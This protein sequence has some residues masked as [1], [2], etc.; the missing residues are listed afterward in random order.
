MDSG[1]VTADWHKV[2]F[3][4]ETSASIVLWDNHFVTRRVREE[5][6]PKCIVKTTKHPATIM[7]W[8]CMSA[9][10]V[11]QVH[12]VKKTVDCCLPKYSAKQNSPSARDMYGE[13]FWFFQDGDASCHWGQV[14]NR[15]TDKERTAQ[16]G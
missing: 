9:K 16:K 2:V 7:I 14:T 3:N 13:G 11:G 6:F 4:D 8:S 5:H 12:I 1:L 10:G 15:L